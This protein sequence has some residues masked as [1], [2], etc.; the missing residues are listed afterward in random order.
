MSE[1]TDALSVLMWDTI[2]KLR[3]PLALDRW[4]IH[5]VAGD[6]TDARAACVADPEYREASIYMDFNR[7]KTGDV[8]DEVIVHEMAHCHTWPLHTLAE[9]LADAL[10]ESAPEP[11]REALRKLLSEQVRYAAE[12]ITTDIGHTYLRLLR[13]AGI[14][15]TPESTP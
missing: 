4:A 8:L 3:E 6:L 15:A 5:P 2:A 10:A 1:P 13:R 7:I 9:S 12:Q 14:L 11:Q